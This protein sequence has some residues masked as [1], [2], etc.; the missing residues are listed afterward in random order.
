MFETEHKWEGTQ[1]CLRRN[2][3]NGNYQCWND[4]TGCIWND[5]HNTCMHPSI[6]DRLY[7]SPLRKKTEQ[8]VEND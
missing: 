3:D 7:D 6:T 8:T 5:G 1:H 2:L 4:H